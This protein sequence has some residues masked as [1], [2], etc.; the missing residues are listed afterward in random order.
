MICPP[1]NNDSYLTD[2]VERWDLIV[3]EKAN[4]TRHP[5]FTFKEC[6]FSFQEK[7]TNKYCQQFK[8]RLKQK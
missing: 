5:D 6:N 7:G 8:S 4:E 3:G 2:Y 1:M